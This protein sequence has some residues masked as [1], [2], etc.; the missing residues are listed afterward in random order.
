M[1]ERTRG[2]RILSGSS[3][4]WSAR[5]GAAAVVDPNSGLVGDAEYRDEKD[6]D[7]LRGRDDC[8]ERV[9]ELV[10]LDEPMLIWD[11]RVESCESKEDLEVREGVLLGEDVESPLVLR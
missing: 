11:I 2:E 9:V 10:L 1:F 8:L 6:E 4:K 5:T 3:E 7:E